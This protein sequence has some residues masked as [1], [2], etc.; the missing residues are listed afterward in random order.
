MAAVAA[1]RAYQNPLEAHQDFLQLFCG[2]EQGQ[3]VL[4]QIL[5]WGFAWGTSWHDDPR[6][7]ACNEGKRILAH[8]I[9]STAT[10]PPPQL[11]T[12]AKKPKGE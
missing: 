1:A 8:K 11:R 5:V 3:R 10:V 2:S 12:R 6:A 7:H 4:R 9:L